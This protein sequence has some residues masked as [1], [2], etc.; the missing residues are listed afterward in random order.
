MEASGD[1]AERWPVTVAPFAGE[2]VTSWL[3]RTAHAHLLEYHTLVN[4]IYPGGNYWDL[5]WDR[6]MAPQMVAVL[7][8]KTGVTAEAINGMLLQNFEGRLFEKMAVDGHTK[9]ITRMAHRKYKN[10]LFGHQYCPG[11]LCK[12]GRDPYFR[13]IWRLS[14]SVACTECGCILH[15]RC[16]RCQSPVLLHQSRFQWAVQGVS[17]LL[18]ICSSCGYDL[19]ASKAVP[20]SLELLQLQARFL[21]TLRNGYTPAV[22]FSHLYFDVVYALCTL[23]LSKSGKKALKVSRFQQTVWQAAGIDNASAGAIRPNATFDSAGLDARM[24]VLLA[25]GW[26]LADWPARLLSLCKQAGV[27]SSTLFRPFKGSI[28]FWFYSPIEVELQQKHAKWRKSAM[29]KAKYVSYDHYGAR[30]LLGRVPAKDM[31]I[32]NLQKPGREKMADV[33]TKEKRSEVM[34]RIRSKDTKPERLFRSILY[35][36]GIRFRKNYPK[37]PGKPDIA[38]IKYKVVIFIDGGFWHGFDLKR[39]RHKLSPAWVEKIEANISRDRKH[40]K[41]LK[42]TGFTVIRFWDHD[43]MDKTE[44]CLQTVQSALRRNGWVGP[45]KHPKQ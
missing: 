31:G 19:R 30:R 6:W 34:S 25:V 13:R 16:P 3:V 39:R 23:M 4:S 29:P 44:K 33:F 45:T 42:K 32:F 20:A 36:N 27:N 8:A 28:P 5:D 26:V 40:G 2:L 41:K 11:C 12:D 7:S 22:H 24:P 38:C 18:A 10:T 35:R 14:L 1:L 21:E 17:N 37:L 15:D 9:W 43:V